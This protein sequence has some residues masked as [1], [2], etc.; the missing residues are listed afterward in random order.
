[1]AAPEEPTAKK[2][3]QALTDDQAVKIPYEL[4]TALPTDTATPIS[5]LAIPSILRARFLPVQLPD[6]YGSRRSEPA[7]SENNLPGPHLCPRQYPY[8]HMSI[9][10][11]V[12][13]LYD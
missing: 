13:H 12:P 3:E 7:E 4:R 8:A 1:M 6:S 5:A 11:Y 2:E 9:Y 10:E